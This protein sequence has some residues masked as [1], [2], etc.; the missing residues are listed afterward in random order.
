[1]RPENL[2]SVATVDGEG[3]LDIIEYKCDLTQ[4]NLLERYIRSVKQLAKLI[5]RAGDSGY[6]LEPVLIAV[7]MVEDFEI[8]LPKSVAGFRV[9]V[10]VDGNCL[11]IV[12]LSAGDAHDAGVCHLISQTG[13]WNSDNLWSIRSDSQINVG[14]WSTKTSSPDLV[15]AIPVTMQQR[16]KTWEE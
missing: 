3:D 15:A 8:S 1:M 4:G 13:S 6:W 16:V 2:V 5:E 12:E 11:F 10:R 7:N 14:C 9:K